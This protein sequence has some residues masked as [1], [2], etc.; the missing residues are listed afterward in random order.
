MEAE[1]SWLHVLRDTLADAAAGLIRLV[2]NII[3]AAVVILVGWLLA[4]LLRGATARGLRMLGRMTTGLARG[5]VTHRPF[6]EERSVT[7]V[8]AIIYWA[9]I[10][11]FLTAATQVLG[12]GIFT[13]WL[14]SVVAY[15]PALFAGLLILLAGFVL[16]LL[17]KDL[18]TA[19]ASSAHVAHAEVL[20]RSV[21]LLI[22][23]M[24]VVIGIDQVASMSRSWW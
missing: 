15:L 13:E 8:A 19:T 1:S 11:L 3:G 2:P 9:T 14:S 4:K 17:A 5:G 10:L 18:V 24:A 16:S 23:S 20:G 22:F 12:L 21:Q 6:I 7:A